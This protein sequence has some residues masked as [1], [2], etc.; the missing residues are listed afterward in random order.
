MDGGPETG[1]EEYLLVVQIVNSYLQLL[2]LRGLWDFQVD[3]SDRG[4]GQGSGS[5]AG[6][7]DVLS[8]YTAVEVKSFK[9]T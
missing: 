8:T 2:H 3:K 7:T 4:L 1:E 5:Q 9:D 6:D